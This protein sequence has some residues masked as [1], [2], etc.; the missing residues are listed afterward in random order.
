MMFRA[1]QSSFELELRGGIRL[2]I[3]EPKLKMVL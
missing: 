2:L 3:L 1:Y